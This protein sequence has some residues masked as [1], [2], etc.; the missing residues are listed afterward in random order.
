MNAS[1]LLS[2]GIVLIFVGFFVVATGALSS[3]GGSSSSGGFILI[4]PIPIVFG[5][6]PS[7]GM[8]ATVGLAI[9]V[10]MVVFYLLSFFLWRSGRRREM[11]AGNVQVLSRSPAELLRAQ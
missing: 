6:G 10:V 7:S 11:D 4:G 2:L 5:N 9:T 8:L 1:R 3:T